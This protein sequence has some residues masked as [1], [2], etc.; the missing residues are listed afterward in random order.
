MRNL[1][2][3]L[4]AIL[5]CMILRADNG[6]VGVYIPQEPKYATPGAE[7]ILKALQSENIKARKLE[8]LN[9]EEL[10]KCDTV[11]LSGMHS[12]AVNESPFWRDFLRLYLKCGGNIILTHDACGYRRV[13]SKPLFPEY[14]KGKYIRPFKT[15]VVKDKSS[16][17]CIGLPDKFETG[18]VDHVVI[19][20]S[21][22]C[23]TAIVNEKGEPVVA[24]VQGQG[25]GKEPGGY[26]VGIGS[27]TGHVS[28]G[29]YNG[30]D[31]IPPA[32]EKKMFLNIIRF[33]GTNSPLN[34]KQFDS[35]SMMLS[36]ILELGK[37]SE[38]MSKQVNALENE[39]KTFK[40][41]EDRMVIVPEP[42]NMTIDKGFC[43]IGK[44]INI[45]VP[46]N[47]NG[48][49]L[50]PAENL[51][52]ILAE[53]NFKSE[54]QKADKESETK[55][56]RVLLGLAEDRLLKEALNKYGFN[57]EEL[58]KHP[59]SYVLLIRPEGIV[60][61][62]NDLRGT[63]WGVQ[64]LIQIV[65]QAKEKEKSTIPC[66]SISDWP[67]MQIRGIV[68]VPSPDMNAM[69]RF[70]RDYVV[71]YKLNLVCFGPFCFGLR[72]YD[73]H[74]DFRWE[75]VKKPW[76]TAM[77]KEMAEYCN[78]YL[79]D[80]CP[81]INCFGHCE[82]LFKNPKYAKF[83]E[84]KGDGAYCPLKPEIRQMFF[85]VIKEQVEIYKP[86]FVLIGHDEIYPI[87]VCPECKK[88]DPADLLA[89]DINAYRDFLAGL[90][91]KTM[92]MGDMLV[93]REKFGIYARSGAPGYPNLESAI[94]KIN[95]DILIAHWDYYRD[96]KQRKSGNEIPVLKYFKD[97]GFQILAAPW[98]GRLNNYYSAKEIL[99]YGGSG[100]LQQACGPAHSR[101]WLTSPATA[102][103]AWTAGKPD[104]NNLPYDPI[105]LVEEAINPKDYSLRASSYSYVDLSRYFNASVKDNGIP[106]MKGDGF[107][108][109]G[110]LK[111]GR[112]IP[113]GEQKYKSLRFMISPEAIICGKVKRLG[114]QPYP[115]I[116]KNI[117]IE[118]K[119]KSVLFVHA[120]N[121]QTGEKPVGFYT[122]K[123][124]N[125]KTQ[126]INLGNRSNI[127]PWS[128]SLEP[129]WEEREP[130]LNA[131]YYFKD[132]T[133][134]HSGATLG[135]DPVTLFAYEWENPF[136]D[137]EIA[138]IDISSIGDDI[139]ICLWA[140]TL[141]N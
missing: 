90:G 11:I 6:E 17:I 19:D 141:Y 73:C 113:C 51:Q 60:I 121:G 139:Q 76:T 132:C 88:H 2:L 138:S 109:D 126:T 64:S 137:D 20:T 108:F 110:W 3:C 83:A 106:G 23:K 136:P 86:P 114:Y 5:F 85:D 71:R 29:G 38:R 115:S 21:S 30:I 102:E 95:K 55:V 37:N 7:G 47:Y 70:V 128:K 82:I 41:T 104:P 123:Y 74:P 78:K 48:K 26:L 28:T 14:F 140:I 125:G 120:Q 22:S 68:T 117:K 135:G 57:F 130:W 45:I 58:K 65:L 97:K 67:D 16:P 94:D 49:M 99:R 100:M 80:A 40:K 131:P 87:G 27:I 62:G 91:V 44:E 93:S 24:W 116:I 25:V 129:G 36:P 15:L 98:F 96:G 111:D 8:L 53:N 77:D 133:S 52:E 59:E 124:K 56:P 75:E 63:L 13:M 33:V 18:Y 61:A 39:L 42:Q 112:L 69:K 4:A 105:R 81:Y 35:M 103:Y 66:L 122:I 43:N 72:Q 101:V 46:G 127:G 134:I 34:K 118:K 1:L 31:A 92:I 32:E 107:L 89:M 119:A 50:F 54:I 12:T 9:P 79:L 10:S 84:R